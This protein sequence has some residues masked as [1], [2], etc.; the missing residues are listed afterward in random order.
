MVI[1]RLRAGIHVHQS[2]LV[3][4]YQPQKLRDRVANA[5]AQN[6]ANALTRG[7]ANAITRGAA[8]AIAQN[9]ANEIPS[10]LQ[11]KALLCVDGT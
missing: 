2:A 3:C 6:P 4:T 9:P 10:V 1:R 8:N 5:T 7:A 11:M